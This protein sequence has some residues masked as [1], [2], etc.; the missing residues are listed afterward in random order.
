MQL[1]FSDAFLCSPLL[2][3]VLFCSPFVS[4]S[5]SAFPII[6]L[7]FPNV[8]DVDYFPFFLILNSEMDDILQM[9]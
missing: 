5:F 8:L 4:I 7:V 2:P 9:D 3:Y 1:M 6:A